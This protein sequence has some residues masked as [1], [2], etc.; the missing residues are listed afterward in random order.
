M[1]KPFRLLAALLTFC[2]AA[3]AIPTAGLAAEAESG[4]FDLKAAVESATD[5]STITLTNDAI[6]NAGNLLT[7]WIIERN[8]TIDGQGHIVIVRAVGILLDT[9]VTF[10]NMDLRLVST[11][12]R[13][14]I[15]A[16]GH[17]LTLDSVTANAHSI[18]IFGGSL[19]KAS[20]EN[21][22]EVPEI[23]RAHV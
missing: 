21:Y 17:S 20:Y 18:N 12:G 2:I 9:D 10:K 3:A 22:Y 13:N 6:V 7:P 8:V 14:A 11:D 1:K 16:N 19:Q 15:I 5:G 23:G 4:Y